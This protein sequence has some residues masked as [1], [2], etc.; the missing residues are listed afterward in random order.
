MAKRV[1]QDFEMKSNEDEPPL[2]K[3]KNNES[4]CI[5]LQ[6]NNVTNQ[7]QKSEYQFLKENGIKMLQTTCLKAIL[8][9]DVLGILWE[10]SEGKW[11]E[12]PHCDFKISLSDRH[13]EVV[14]CGPSC[15]NDYLW[16]CCIGCDIDIVECVDDCEV[17]ND[18]YGGYC[19]IHGAIYCQKCVIHCA[20][21]NNVDC[22]DYCPH[23]MVKCDLC[24]K[25]MCPNHFKSMDE[26][27][28]FDSCNQYSNIVCT[29]CMDNDLE[30][31][32][33]N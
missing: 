16:F 20:Y 28:L 14:C 22:Q 18:K 23:C 25:I 11:S 4:S 19:S 2:K 7:N 9:D 10:F 1:I 21:D 26:N 33:N 30:N 5:Q 12:C 8:S 32:T 6:I 15:G 17:C 3:M 27:E 24:Q 13:Q 29:N 31:T